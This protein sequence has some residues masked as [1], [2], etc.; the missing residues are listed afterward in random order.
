MPAIAYRVNNWLSLGL[1]LNIMYGILNNKV[2][3][4]N[5][6]PRLSDG[7]MKLE[8]ND[9]GLGVDLGVLLEPIDGTRFGVQYLSK[10]DLNFTDKPEFNNL[11]PGLSRILQARGLLDAELNLGMSV[12]QTVMISGYHELSDR[13]AL[14]ANLGWQDWSS[15]GKVDVGI[16]ST[17][18]TSI[19]KSINYQ[20]TWHAALG[21]QY[22]PTGAWCLSTGV[23]YDSSMV[24]DADRTPSVAVGEA[25]RFGLGAQYRWSESLTLGLAYEFLWSGD[26]K[27]DQSRPLAGRLSGEYENFNI[28]FFTVNLTWVF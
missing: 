23:A 11:G 16:D 25:Y 4:N 8:S 1:G 28:H 27:V 7:Q 3:I 2:A 20:D 15:F 19:T 21:F 17:T 22:R 24:N 9:W 14:L 6:D 12:P 13:F 5:I 10:V 26:L 18:P